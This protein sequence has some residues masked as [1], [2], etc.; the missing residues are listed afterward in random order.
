MEVKYLENSI[1]RKRV[2]NL[3]ESKNLTQKDLADKC[4]TTEATISRNLNGIHA[5]RAE[6][7]EKIASVLDVTTDYLLGIT[8]N[9]NS[10]KINV[11]DADGTTMQLEYELLNKI[12]GLT[13]TD[14]QK[15]SEYVDFIKM[16]KGNKKNEK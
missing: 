14:L 10:V 8:N 13:V 16:Q 11:A 12:S 7:I 6:I 3:L 2:K 15:I 4:Q 1:L 5:P 9:P